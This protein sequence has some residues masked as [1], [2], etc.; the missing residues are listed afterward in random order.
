MLVLTLLILGFLATRLI[1]LSIFPIFADEAIYIRWAQLI[2]QGKYFIPLSDG[3]TPLFM[4]LLSPILQIIK[5]P[6]IA[7][8][9]L[10]VFSGLATLIGIYFLTKKL[11]TKRIALIASVLTVF[12]PFL[13]FYDR[14]SLTD[15]LLT[16]LI[17]WIVYFVLLLLEKPKIKTAFLL[18]LLFA[19]VLLTKPSAAL[20]LA[21]TPSLLFLY[22][23][24]KWLN[25]IK[26]VLFPSLLASIIGFGIYSLQRFSNAF[27]LI[28]LRSQD[29]LRPLSE[30]TSNWLE[31]F[32]DT[33]KVI[34]SWQINY[35]SWPAIALLL[36]SSVLVLKT[37][38][39]KT[40]PLFILIIAP[41]IIQASIGKIIYPR[42]LL[43]T[44]PFI[45]IILSFGLEK[46]KKPLSLLFLVLISFYWLKFDYLLLTN[47]Q[48]TPLDFW[49][50]NQYFY[51]WSS[52]YGLKEI[53]QYLASIPQDQSV[54]VVTEGSFG[55]L[56]DGLQIYFNSSPNVRI[57]GI[58]FP[59]NKINASMEQSLLDNRQVYLV[60]NQSRFG[61][62]DQS[63]LELINEYPRQNN[64]KLLFF[65][66]LPK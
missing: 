56:P 36:I 29:Y 32:P 7:G 5:D 28:N 24:K 30:I 19:A 11:F 21:C 6:L 37:K 62:S 12:N 20:Y 4:W 53:T 26:S 15:S 3:K 41:I 46:L 38:L 63:R 49:E 43:P 64:D 9:L 61:G 23:S 16:A 48:N 52:G 44:I 25:K 1:N 39:K 65:K 58:G 2:W 34:L 27:H 13:L 57:Q 31:F 14:L 22:P 45:L 10:S 47:P 33:L 42:Y 66:V 54:L 17:V 60:F 18:G 59:E 55:T 8:R 51:Q 35:L 50:K 40:Y